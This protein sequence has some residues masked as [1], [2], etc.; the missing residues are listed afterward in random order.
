MIA[1]FEHSDLCLIKLDCS[2]VNAA[3]LKRC[4]LCHLNKL[5]PHSSHRIKHGV[6][7]FFLTPWRRVIIDGWRRISYRLKLLTVR[8]S[9][10]SEIGL[11][12]GSPKTWNLNDSEEFNEG[13]FAASR[14]CTENKSEA[15]FEWA[16]SWPQLDH[17][18][19]MTA[20]DVD[21]SCT[22]R[23]Q[24]SDSRWVKGLQRSLKWPSTVQTTNRLN[25]GWARSG[26]TADKERAMSAPW[27]NVQWTNN[28][29]AVNP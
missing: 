7:P 22:E 28:R 6:G 16:V 25:D 3:L 1:R 29:H 2:C 21:L 20:P 12:T 13:L 10:M 27:A 23:E 11:A 5:S 17:G 19:T 8:G 4:D 15:N 9:R 14:L 26:P 24:A 18:R